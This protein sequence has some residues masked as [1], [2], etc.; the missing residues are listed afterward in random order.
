IIQGRR[1]FK[2]EK[3]LEE[4]PYFKARVTS[5]EDEWPESEEDKKE[6]NAYSSSIRDLATQI[7]KL[8][9]NIP[10]EASVILN[11]IENT[12]FLI[13][14]VASNLSSGLNEKQ[15]LLTMNDLNGKAE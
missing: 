14:F 13:H 2:V 6:F 10:S 4:D 11:N 5:L 15:Q 7:I 12:S 1:R 3:I 8:S 9:P